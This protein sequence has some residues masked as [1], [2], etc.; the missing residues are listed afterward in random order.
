[1]VSTCAQLQLRT[2]GVYPFAA[3]PADCDA[4]ICCLWRLSRHILRTPLPLNLSTPG[5]FPPACLHVLP[6]TATNVSLPTRM[7]ISE[8]VS[9]NDVPS[10]FP[11]HRTCTARG[12]RS[13][14]EP[15]L[16]GPEPPV[17]G[18]SQGRQVHELRVGQR[19]GG[20]SWC[21]RPRGCGDEGAHGVQGTRA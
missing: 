14:S 20:G 6:S 1:M 3:R 19:Q 11:I 13:P 5:F 2:S 4:R 15:R 16:P 9:H 8:R 7:P 21:R 18:R 10:N 17:A 12:R